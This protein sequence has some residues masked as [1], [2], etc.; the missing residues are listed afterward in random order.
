MNS[1]RGERAESIIQQE[2]ALI[3]ARMV[4][5]E[6]GITTVSRVEIS[7]DRKSA[8]VFMSCFEPE[9]EKELLKWLNKNAALIYQALSKNVRIKY[10]PRLE[11]KKE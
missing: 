1:W 10:L 2:L 5:S 3:L 8:K 4:G 6:F 9:K 11:F 7:G